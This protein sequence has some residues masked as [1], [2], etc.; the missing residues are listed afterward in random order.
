[1]NR[2]KTRTLLDKILITLIVI[3]NNMLM[4]VA[5]GKKTTNK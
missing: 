2:E 5:C 4:L 1:M 3:I